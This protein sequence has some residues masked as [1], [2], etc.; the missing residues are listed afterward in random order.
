M[1]EEVL[2]RQLYPELERV[3]RRI[4]EVRLALQLASAQE[5]VAAL[6]LPWDSRVKVFEQ[7]DRDL[8]AEL[9]RLEQDLEA[10]R[11]ANNPTVLEDGSFERIQQLA[12]TNLSIPGCDILTLLD[13]PEAERLGIRKGSLSEEERRAIESHVTHSYHF[14]KKILWSRDLARVPE[15]AYAHHEKLNG[16][17]Y[18]RGL[19]AGKI[20]LESKMMTIADIYDALTAW[21]RPYKKAIPA[22]KALDILA[23]EAKRG[24][25]DTELLRIFTLGKVYAIVQPPAAKAGGD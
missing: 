3:E 23:D 15:I 19:D 16:K 10:I 9:A 22:E 20:P 25:I 6:E 1:R 5:K 11:G 12:K 14:L 7:L 13:N 8:K 4:R 18:P 21:D 2:V 24:A 17:G